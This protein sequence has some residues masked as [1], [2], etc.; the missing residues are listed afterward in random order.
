MSIHST[1]RRSFL[2]GLG[3]TLTLPA[4]EA[5]HPRIATAATGSG[6]IRMGF[7]YIPNGVIMNKWTPAATG[8]DYALTPTLKSLA[9]VK[10]RIQ[11]LSGL[12]HEKAHANGDGAGDHA[13]ANATFLTGVQARK[14]SGADIQL[15]ISVDQVAAQQ[16]GSQTKL[17]SLELTCT[18]ARRSGNC[19]SGYSCA[20]QHNL[21]WKSPTTPVPAEVDPR[22]VFERMFGSQDSGENRKSRLRRARQRKS[23]LDFVANDASRLKRQVGY[24][25]RQKLDEYLTSVREVEQQVE[26]AERFAGTLPDMDAP[27]GVPGK[28]EDH[29]RIMYDMMAIAFQSDI[30]RISTFLMAYDGSG[31][32]F[33]NLGISGGHHNLSH[34]K[35]E[36]AKIKQLEAIDEFYV[37]QFAYFLNKLKSI[38]EADGTLLDNCMIVCGSGIS[39]GNRHSHRDLPVILAGGGG[40]KLSVG[41]H[42]RYEAGT[43]MTNLYL[44]ML[45]NMGVRTGKLGDS[46]GRLKNV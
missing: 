28:Y 29:V 46:T 23:I 37:S 38:K 25:D 41:R 24:S 11:I 43:P 7:A 45:D 12:D 6:P 34:H 22:M 42:V 9:P 4:L 15:G 3:V 35:G 26:K 39:D 16:I 17:A 8:N 20:Y 10:D 33:R 14:T 31:H 5:L 18:R 36:Q 32:V 30:T 21:S 1:N 40:G 27:K 19:D 44:S 2:R 13:R